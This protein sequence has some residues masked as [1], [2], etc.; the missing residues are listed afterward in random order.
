MNITDT[1][2]PNFGP[3]RDGLKPELVVVHYTAMETSQAA[4]QR[5]CAPE[6]EVSAHYLITRSGAIHRMVAEDQRAWHAGAGAWGGRG[7]VNSRSIG[8]ELT[9]RGVEPFAARQMDSLE[10]LLAGILGRWDIPA[11]G[12]IG[13]ACMAPGR[14]ADP[15]PR[16]DWQRL[17]R[18]GLAVWPEV[19]VGGQG[20]SADSAA[21]AEGF[22]EAAATFGY[23]RSSD[24]L[25]A[26][27]QRFRPWARGRV[28]DEWDV[29]LAR[30]LAARHPASSA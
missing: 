3:R 15:G 18:K 24:T 13:H 8:I 22:A 4:L 14:K 11:R 16:F 5:L 25:D 12:V 23:P 10:A 2:S 29:A 30:A 6:H 21:L 9:N 19:G 1:P 28:L 20:A 27:R 17:A 7:D 26:F